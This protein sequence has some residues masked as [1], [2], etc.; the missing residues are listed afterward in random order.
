M[1][2]DVVLYGFLA[3]WLE[4]ALLR[5]EPAGSFKEAHTWRSI[6]YGTYYMV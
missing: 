1:L 5:E 4:Q 3:W 6:L 2:V